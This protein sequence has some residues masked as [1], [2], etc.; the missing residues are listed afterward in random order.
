RTKEDPATKP[1]SPLEPIQYETSGSG[2]LIS[3]LNSKPGALK[4]NPRGIIV[5]LE[6]CG[7]RDAGSIRG[8]IRS[9]YPGRGRGAEGAAHADRWRCSEGQNLRVEVYFK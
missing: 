4:L 8:V 7:R 6:G 9:A 2:H 5:L 1:S 3:A